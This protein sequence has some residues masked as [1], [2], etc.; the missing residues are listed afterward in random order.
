[1]MVKFLVGMLHHMSYGEQKGGMWKPKKVK[2]LPIYYEKMNTGNH[3]DDIL[4]ACES[5]LN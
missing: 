2:M 4:G 1:M 5:T 3:D